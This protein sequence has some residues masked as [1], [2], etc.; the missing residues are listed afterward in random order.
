MSVPPPGLVLQ[1]D[2]RGAAREAE[3]ALAVDLHREALRRTLSVSVTVT[4][5]FAAVIGPTLTFITPS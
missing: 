5:N 1:L 2:R 4:S 3:R